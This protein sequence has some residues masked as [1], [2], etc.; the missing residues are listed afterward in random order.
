MPGVVPPGQR[1]P[2]RQ[3]IT[4]LEAYGSFN[5][6]TR[7]EVLQHVKPPDLGLPWPQY[8]GALAA[9]TCHINWILLV[10]WLSW[11]FCD[12]DTLDEP[13]RTWVP[14]AVF[15]SQEQ[16]SECLR[17]HFFASTA[18]HA[19]SCELIITSPPEN[20]GRFLLTIFA[21][22]FV[23]MQTFLSWSTGT[24]FPM[25]AAR[26]FYL[27]YAGKE[28][29]PK[30][31]GFTFVTAAC[32]FMMGL[33]FLY[34][35]MWAGIVLFLR[36]QDTT[37]TM[38]LIVATIQLALLSCCILTKLRAVVICFAIYA[39]LNC[40]TMHLSPLSCGLTAAVVMLWILLSH[41]FRREV[42]SHSLPQVGGIFSECV[43]FLYR[44]M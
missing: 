33:F 6:D 44:Q 3:N 32:M 18:H 14:R 26:S 15:Y 2:L 40:A 23:V 24:H 25:T 7:I 35:T 28:V 17:P 42:G 10:C 5:R 1:V 19:A 27:L 11:S 9:V 22:T 16:L 37:S 36:M 12:W 34:C 31:T 30:P 29:D 38:V 8:L 41:S 39:L 43:E 21:A 4:D 13:T 20:R